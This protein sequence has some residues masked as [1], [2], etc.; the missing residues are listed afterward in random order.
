MCR[1]IS[2]FSLL[3]S[4]LVLGLGCSRQF[5]KD[6]ATAVPESAADSQCGPDGVRKGAELARDLSQEAAQR[7]V[8]ETSGNVSWPARQRTRWRAV[9]VPNLALA[10]TPALR[11]ELGYQPKEAVL[12]IDAYNSL[13]TLLV[14]QVESMPGMTTLS[15]ALAEEGTVYFRIRSARPVDAAH[16]KLSCWWKLVQEEPERREPC[17]AVMPRHED[18]PNKWLEEGLQ[19]RIISAKYVQGRLL[20]KLDKGTLAGVAIGDN[21][22]ILEG[23]S[24]FEPLDGGTFSV[25]EV[26][27][28]ES[29]GVTTLKSRGRIFRIVFPR[30]H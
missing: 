20:L 17:C 8:A 1:W 19:G 2:G 29:V 21:G 24:G 6:D 18:S 25:I 22:V 30:K 26:S 14:S 15:I 11:C 7:G 4:C 10:E 23:R 28:S 5:R 3:V 16:F 27:A 9:A 13:G 12:Q